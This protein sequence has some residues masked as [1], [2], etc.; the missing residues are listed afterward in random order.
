MNITEIMEN[1]SKN[2]LLKP[3]LYRKEVIIEVSNN[4]MTFFFSLHEEG[5][6]IVDDETSPNIRIRGKQNEL[7][8]IFTGKIKL[9]QSIKM[10]LI[11]FEGTYRSL[12][13][14]ESILWMN[15]E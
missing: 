5:V 3:L 4:E 6:F 11:K 10:G 14:L 8:E 9:Q 13:N 2:Q 12:L 15:S 7:I 1:L